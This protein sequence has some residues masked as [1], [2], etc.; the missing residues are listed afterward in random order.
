MNTE[1]TSLFY[2]ANLGSEVERIFSLKKKGMD[3]EAGEAY[4]RALDIIE[5]LTKHPELL[6]R[7]GEIKLL[8]DYLEESLKNKSAAMNQ[9]EWQ[10]YFLP[11]A[12]RL[13]VPV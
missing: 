11:Y 5:K 6:N 8:K 7:T 9:R 2:M 12:T 1:R 4:V 3:K 10:N 13:L